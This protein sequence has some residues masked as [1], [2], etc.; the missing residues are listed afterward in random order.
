MKAGLRVALLGLFLL[1]WP[2][3]AA[4]GPTLQPT[5]VTVIQV[6][7]QPSRIVNGS[8]LVF[9]VQSAA[10]FKSLTGK[11]LGHNVLFYRS[12]SDRV[13]YGLAGVDVQTPAGTYTLHLEAVD[14]DGTIV[15]RQR[16]LRI[17]KANYP[18][19]ALR[20]ADQYVTPDAVTLERIEREKALKHRVFS[21]NTLIPEWSGTFTVPVQA[22]ISLPFGASR[23]FNGKLQSIHRGIDYRVPGGTEV[24]AANS[25]QV[26]LARELFYEGNCV[27]IDHG[28][29]LFTAYLH[30]SRILVEEGQSVG[31]GQLLGLSGATGRVTGP[32]LHLSVIWNSIAVDPAELF[33]L[34][35]PAALLPPAVPASA[36]K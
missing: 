2:V 17:S 27:V 28:Q 8:L 35:I 7:W 29:G 24:M 16:Q 34:K 36:A 26:V 21:R 20:V 6:A 4:D 23:V 25:G 9:Q 3:A 18:R 19:T 15:H 14:A 11:W 33:K 1:N 10:N 22:Q 5:R 12:Q 32:H 13:W 31:D 30:L